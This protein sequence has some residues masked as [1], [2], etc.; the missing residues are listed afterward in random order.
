MPNPLMRLGNGARTSTD[1]PERV[2]PVPEEYE[3]DNF[4][5]RG[6]QTHG[7]EPVHVPEEM[8]DWEGVVPAEYRVVEPEPEPT[9]VRIV[10]TGGRELHKWQVRRDYA[11][12]VVSR[13][14]GRNDARTT[15]RVR[16]LGASSTTAGTANAATLADN[17]NVAA[18]G[19][20]GNTFDL[21]TL[22]AD[23]A[24]VVVHLVVGAPGGV[25][26]SVTYHLEESENGAGWIS[27]ANVVV[28]A[29]GTFRL[30]VSGPLPKLVRVRA[31]DLSAGGSFPTTVL[32][33]ANTYGE[34]L[35][36]V[37]DAATI[38]V[39]ASSSVQPYTGYPVPQGGEFSL[40][41]AEAEV[42][43]VSADGSQVALA[44]LEEFTV[45]P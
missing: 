29:A 10:Q 30:G 26:P 23:V 24:G 7:V 13:V 38:W 22:G 43:V 37:T 3:G 9:P 21:S 18:N 39:G 41:K 11:T 5:Y 17:V 31:S 36:T 6:T 45:H 44:V 1:A 27:R 20:V 19:Q 2:V 16:N 4:P 14:A 42:W 8:R 28:G 34:Q 35:G 15:L 12:G 33:R 25:A 40:D 32:L